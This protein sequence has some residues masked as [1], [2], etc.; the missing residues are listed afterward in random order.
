MEGVWKF[1]LEV[2]IAFHLNKPSS[3]FRPKRLPK[4]VED[5]LL[6]SL[7]AF[8]TIAA[9]SYI[10]SVF[11]FAELPIFLVFLFFHG[12]CKQFWRLLY[13]INFYNASN[14]FFFKH[15]NILFDIQ[16]ILVEV[17]HQQGFSLIRCKSVLLALPYWQTQRKNSHSAWLVS[18]C[19]REIKVEL[20]LSFSF[21]HS[22]S[23]YYMHMALLFY[24][25][26]QSMLVI[27]S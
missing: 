25:L 8:R 12:F 9:S 2:Y 18:N 15:N 26:L 13:S 14:S 7:L 3:P 16:S 6:E 23:F 10:Y 27:I 1:D 24:N 11:F 22:W 5:S 4:L 19:K 21:L 17:Q 20:I